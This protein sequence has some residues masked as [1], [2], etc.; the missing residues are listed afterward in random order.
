MSSRAPE[1]P[2]RGLS[3]AELYVFKARA[4]AGL[5]G[6]GVALAGVLTAGCG[7]VQ[8]ASGNDG[9]LDATSDGRLDDGATS[10]RTL[11]DGTVSDGAMA[12]RAVVDGRGSDGAIS[13]AQ[14][15]DEFSIGPLYGAAACDEP[16]EIPD[17]GVSVPGAC[18]GNDYVAITSDYSCDGGSANACDLTLLAHG[19]YIGGYDPCRGMIYAVCVHGSYSACLPSPPLDG[20]VQPLPDGDI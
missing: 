4:A 16:L 18:S 5:V 11:V 14:F 13:D 15:S 9:M 2:P 6:S 10:D 20:S 19:C 3:R 1:A 8:P 12:D 7:E 17:G